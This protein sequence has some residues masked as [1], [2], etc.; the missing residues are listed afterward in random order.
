MREQEMT[1]SR[2]RNSSTY[3]CAEAQ[4]LLDA[5][6]E[7][8]R[9]LVVLLEMQFQSVVEGDESASRFDLLIHAANEKKQSAKYVYMSH[10]EKHGCSLH[11]E[12]DHR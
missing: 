12:T 6:G 11:H 3:Y 5:F 9:E 1:E 7:A 10:L 4:A 2:A 8:V